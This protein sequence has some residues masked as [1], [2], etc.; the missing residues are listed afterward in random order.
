MKDEYGM[1]RDQ[2]EVMKMKL[3]GYPTS[4]DGTPLP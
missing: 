3:R 4:S 1:Q 2:R